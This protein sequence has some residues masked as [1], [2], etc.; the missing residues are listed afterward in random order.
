[1][2]WNGNLISDIKLKHW[3]YGLTLWAILCSIKGDENVENQIKGARIWHSPDIVFYPGNYTFKFWVLTGAPCTAHCQILSRAIGKISIKQRTSLETFEVTIKNSTKH[4]E[5]V[6]TFQKAGKYEIRCEF[7][8]QEH[9]A[10][11]TSDVTI[12]EP[13]N[14]VTFTSNSP[15]ANGDVVEV[16]INLGKWNN[17]SSVTVFYNKFLND[18]EY[19]PGSRFMFI[20]TE[21]EDGILIQRRIDEIGTFYMLFELDI[22]LEGGDM[23]FAAVVVPMTIYTEKF[24]KSVTVNFHCATSFYLF[25]DSFTITQNE[26]KTPDVAVPLGNILHI[27]GISTNKSSEWT[28]SLGEVLISYK[29]DFN[30]TLNSTN[31]T[32]LN[33]IVKNGIS[34]FHF[35]LLLNPMGVTEGILIL[36]NVTATKNSNISLE[37]VVASNVP[38]EIFS[39]ANDFIVS[40]NASTLSTNKTIFSEL[41]YKNKKICFDNSWSIEEYV[42][43]WPDINLHNFN[44]K[45]KSYCLLHFKLTFAEFGTHY[46]T[47]DV[48]NKLTHIREKSKICVSQFA[49]CPRLQAKIKTQSTDGVIK[50]EEGRNIVLSGEFIQRPCPEMPNKNTS[51]SF[52]WT[53]SRIKKEYSNVSG[54]FSDNHSD[55]NWKSKRGGNSE[56][57][58]S[59][60]ILT[61]GFYYCVFRVADNSFCEDNPLYSSDTLVI[62]ILS[63][64]LKAKIKGAKEFIV[65]VTSDSTIHLE[66]EQKYTPDR[67]VRYL[68][69]CRKKNE[70]AAFRK[71]INKI[72]FDEELPADDG[73]CFSNGFA[74]SDFSGTHE[75]HLTKSHKNVLSIR[76]SKFDILTGVHLFRLVIIDKFGNIAF[77][78][79]TILLKVAPP[80]IQTVLDMLSENKT[81]GQPYV[82]IHCVENCG[83][84][85]ISTKQFHLK[86]TCENCVDDISLPFNVEFEW[87]IK[88]PDSKSS[89]FSKIFSWSRDSYTAKRGVDL[90]LKSSAFSQIGTYSISVNMNARYKDSKEQYVSGSATYY[91]QVSD[92]PPPKICFISPSTGTA[93]FTKF[94]IG[95]QG[96][97]SSYHITYE[98][99]YVDC[100]QCNTNGIVFYHGNTPHAKGVALPH[101]E[102]GYGYKLIITIRSYNEKTCGVSESFVMAKITP[103]APEERKYLLEQHIIKDHSLLDEAFREKNIVEFARIASSSLSI[104]ES[105]Q[106]ESFS[107]TVLK[108]VTKKLENIKPDSLQN[109]RSL[110][111][112]LQKATNIASSYKHT[113][114]NT[115]EDILISTEKSTS[116]IAK[117]LKHYS[118]LETESSVSFEG[119]SKD[120]LSAMSSQLGIV[121]ELETYKQNSSSAS[122]MKKAIRKG[123]LKSLNMVVLTASEH[124]SMDEKA[125]DLSV[126]NIDISVTKSKLNLLSPGPF[127]PQTGLKIDVGPSEAESNGGKFD[128]STGISTF[129]SHPL[130]SFKPNLIT[131]PNERV[132]QSFIVGISLKIENLGNE[133][134]SRARTES[135]GGNFNLIRNKTVHVL[136]PFPPKNI[137]S[138][139]SIN[140]P[141]PC[142][143]GHNQ[144]FVSSVTQ[145]CGYAVASL[146]LDLSA[147][148]NRR[149]RSLVESKYKNS[150]IV[151]RPSRPCRIPNVPCVKLSFML[152]INKKE[153]AE[154]IVEF[155]TGECEN[156]DLLAKNSKC[157]QAYE[158]LYNTTLPITKE[159]SSTS[160]FDP[161]PWSIPTPGS[162]LEQSSSDGR[163]QIIVVM[164]HLQ[165]DST[166]DDTIS[167]QSVSLTFASASC[168]VWNSNEDSWNDEYCGVGKLSKENMI[169]CQCGPQPGK[170]YDLAS[171]TS[172]DEDVP[173]FFTSALIITPNKIEFN[174]VVSLFLRL[175]SHYYVMVVILLCWAI[176]IVPLPWARRDDLK[177]YT[178]SDIII[179]EDNN[180][181]HSYLYEVVVSTAMLRGAGTTAKVSIILQGSKGVSTKP[182]II[183]TPDCSTLQRAGKDSFLIATPSSLGQVEKLRV[184]H[185]NGGENPSWHLN[186]IAVFDLHNPECPPSYFLINK[187]LSMDI[188]PFRCE[189]EAH[190]DSTKRLASFCHLWKMFLSQIVSEEDVWLSF[191]F[192]PR[193]SSF[194]RVQRL[195]CLAVAFF[196]TMLIM[197]M[198][199]EVGGSS[200]YVMTIGFVEFD[201]SPI[202]IAFEG[203]IVTTP[204]HVILA[205]FICRLEPYRRIG[206]KSLA[207]YLKTLQKD[208]SKWTNIKRQESYRSA[209]SDLNI[210]I[211][212]DANDLMPSCGKKHNNAV[213]EES[214][215]TYI[216]PRSF[217]KSCIVSDGIKNSDLFESDSEGFLSCESDQNVFETLETCRE[218]KKIAYN[219]KREC[220]KYEVNY[221]NSSSTKRKL[222]VRIRDFPIDQETPIVAEQVKELETRQEKLQQRVWYKRFKSKRIM[223]GLRRKHAKDNR[224]KPSQFDSSFHSLFNTDGGDADSTRSQAYLEPNM[225]LHDIVYMPNSKSFLPGWVSGVVWI[226]IV[227]YITVC[228]VLSLVYGL[229]YR[230]VKFVEWFTTFCLSLFQTLF[231]ITPIRLIVTAAIYAVLNGKQIDPNNWAAYTGTAARA[232]AVIRWRQCQTSSP[233]LLELNVS[234]CFN[235]SKSWIGP[236]VFPSVRRIKTGKRSLAV[237]Q[238]K[239]Y[240]YDTFLWIALTG[241]VT[242]LIVTQ[243]DYRITR[244]SNQVQN[245]FHDSLN[246]VKRKGELFDFLDNSVIP[247]LYKTHELSY[248]DQMKVLG[249]IRLRQLRFPSDNECNC[250]NTKLTRAGCACLYPESD[251]STVN[252]YDKSHY[253]DSWNNKDKYLGNNI[254]FVSPW[255]YQVVDVNSD[256]YFQPGSIL[257]RSFYPADGYVVDIGYKMKQALSVSKS[258]KYAK[259]IDRKSAAVFLEFALL[260]PVSGHITAATFVFEFLASGGVNKFYQAHSY[261]PVYMYNAVDIIIVCLQVLHIFVTFAHLY[262]LF[263]DCSDVRW[264]AL[265][266]MNMFLDIW[267]VLTMLVVVVTIAAYG[268]YIMH[269]VSAA[270]LTRAFK[271]DPSQFLSFSKPAYFKIIYWNLISFDAFLCYIHLLK[272]LRGSRSVSIMTYTL[273]VATESIIGVA[274]LIAIITIASS[275]IGKVSFGP[276]RWNFHSFLTAST[277][278]TSVAAGMDVSH[279]EF[280][281]TKEMWWS[282]YFCLFAF[283]TLTLYTNLYATVLSDALFF[284][285]NEATKEEAHQVETLALHWLFEKTAGYLG[286]KSR[287]FSDKR[288]KLRPPL[289]SIIRHDITEA[290]RK[291][292][293][294]DPVAI[295]GSERCITNKINNDAM[296]KRKLMRRNSNLSEKNDVVS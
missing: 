232:N 275:L 98:M 44:R 39:R 95:C 117:F 198:F 56:F 11:M 291:S 43:R 266:I 91:A 217:V 37:L 281:V 236:D 202:I 251:S 26:Q 127:Y 244:I 294:L 192:K 17:A 124:K 222:K 247:V 136:V 25:N 134:N 73:G 151:V 205:E 168:M 88:E 46:V 160:E 92:S 273:S 223:R 206:D 45:S 104:L 10:L 216:P 259:W 9:S 16:E 60:K 34:A 121:S 280:G 108:S 208:K 28:W 155:D 211:V 164:E 182:H 210:G 13:D 157:F 249:P 133:T 120:V 58:L 238:V 239:R 3:I 140:L 154:K 185:D 67:D 254:T 295:T 141:K 286:L 197:N 183:S 225:F 29:S 240:W 193:C 264:K 85:I 256:T 87:F 97:T 90:K 110:S 77:D 261:R 200:Y 24:N 148:S 290:M 54:A 63:P 270:Q 184:W 106:D 59:S 36:N 143:A 12:N 153:S 293:T 21:V 271:N 227:T 296:N 138:S 80:E 137:I 207:N 101:G 130:G 68:W 33:G 178:L 147:L 55:P 70:E 224:N 196:G 231:I 267:N 212:K 246:E 129:S 4:Y 128:I 180:T 47:V 131:E 119:V 170:P 161:D 194:T 276:Q 203:A 279:P 20:F 42:K 125:T 221:R 62:Q 282:I 234:R 277:T 248:L 51:I 175:R 145:S 241:F 52:S 174:D 144:T 186:R 41:P 116:I 187:W 49:A 23:K 269:I 263:N 7:K 38:K 268:Y 5:R 118:S 71:Y 167:Y 40:V 214:S 114:S 252:Y 166:S 22:Y 169:H 265:S 213:T 189:I 262:S 220:E 237:R 257:H 283:F 94:D 96:H 122:D 72:N 50:L 66:S 245:Y 230:K 112:V 228:S 14:P 191:F 65:Y 132:E 209:R 190:K 158:V 32:P 64:P 89:D 139:L 75:K 6:V 69:F 53:V 250:F 150:F 93:L 123:M 179:P 235:K 82:A 18:T 31:P 152:P 176:F 226:L 288:I 76:V 195:G 111:Q 102:K 74:V 229:S 204:I 188:Y 215:G 162:L 163:E 83:K 173:L 242:F 146:D 253:I 171:M 30:L 99:S 165:S 115:I 219:I 86:A 84:N 48:K 113:S 181:K 278:L 57:F 255:R 156:L 61:P 287:A 105:M 142:L 274:T 135:S 107:D 8:N 177:S 1:M 218:I 27:E 126:K 201:L 79:R 149:K 2:F 272:I 285:K 289:G 159:T 258:L 78:D 15:V 100:H 19:E 109:A 35:S 199:F 81:E 103:P 172:D 233:T 292:L 260:E 243:R 284:A